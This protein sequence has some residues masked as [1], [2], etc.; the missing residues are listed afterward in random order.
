VSTH[1]DKV[2]KPIA[3]APPQLSHCEKRVQSTTISLNDEASTQAF[4]P[5]LSSGYELLFTCGTLYIT[6]K[7]P[8]RFSSTKSNKGAAG[9]QPWRQGSTTR[10]VSR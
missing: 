6:T 4:M 2:Y 7:A 5:A 1:V 9:V 10:F 8:S 3:Q